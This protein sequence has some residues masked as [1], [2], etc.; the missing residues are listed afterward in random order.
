MELE[1]PTTTFRPLQDKRRTVPEPPPVRLL[2][3]DDV[4]Q[5]AVA[6]L[7]KSLDDFYVT[8]L[9][10]E[11]D[12]SDRSCVAYKAER[13][14]ICFDVIERPLPREDYRPTQI[15][16]PHFVDFIHELKKR[17]VEF[18]WQK[19]IGPGSEVALLQDPAGHWVSVGPI[20]AVK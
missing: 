6:G 5:T 19:G 8:L 17:E 13:F 7:E 1:E 9:K 18:E 12:A 11:R 16:I 15:E 3:I 2:A 14:R 10:F 4:R 20:I